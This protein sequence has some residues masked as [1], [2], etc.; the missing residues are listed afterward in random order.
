ME[1]HQRLRLSTTDGDD[2][3]KLK[4]TLSVLP[5]Y[6]RF[7]G[8]PSAVIQLYKVK[9]DFIYFPRFFDVEA[10]SNTGAYNTLEDNLSTG[11]LWPFDVHF[12]GELTPLQLRATNACY[13]Q[14]IKGKA[15][16]RVGENASPDADSAFR[17]AVDVN[18]DQRG[19]VKYVRH[20]GGGAIL[21]LHCG[22]GKTVCALQL[23]SRFRV[24]TLVIVHKTFLMDQWRKRISKFIPSA[25]VGT[26]QRDVV[27]VEGHDIVLAMLQSLAVKTYSLSVLSNF[28]LCVVDECHHISAP[29]FSNAMWNIPSRYVIGLSATPRRKDGLTCIMNW[30]LG[31]IAFI[32]AQAMDIPVSVLNLMIPSISTRGDVKVSNRY[33]TEIIT[34]L[35]ENEVRNHIIIDK[36]IECAYLERKILVLSDRRL[37]LET[38]CKLL[39]DASPEITAG[40]YVGGM[41]ERELETSVQC[42]VLFGTYSMSSEGLDIPLLDTLVLSTPR[43]DIVQSVGRIARKHDDKCEPLIID[44]I[45]RDEPGLRAGFRKRKVFYKHQGYSIASER[46]ECTGEYYFGDGGESQSSTNSFMDDDNEES[47]DEMIEVPR[48]SGRNEASRLSVIG[49][50]LQGKHWLNLQSHGYTSDDPSHVEVSNANSGNEAF[51]KYDRS[52]MYRSNEKTA[53]TESKSARNLGNVDV[54]YLSKPVGSNKGRG[55]IARKQGS[56]TI[57]IRTDDIANDAG[58]CRGDDDD[59]MVKS[60]R[61]RFEKID[62]EGKVVSTF[63]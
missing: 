23:M 45:D 52:G 33:Q 17:D 30:F 18:V 12:Q 29:V 27:D 22:A 13:V 20:T 60:K 53:N 41:K 26:I 4:D 1:G 5:F 56:D 49:R 9:N 37:H 36:V 14:M 38:L 62:E 44:V 28:G 43:T 59:C 11:V 58:D 15:G 3:K 63:F 31:P 57:C 51:E 7:S 48:T 24:K 2:L 16:I 40:Y 47:A 10:L 50:P 32:S 6:S 42:T 34:R 46:Y 25:S 19:S 54:L 61:G 21:S 39:R 8:Q 55:G 35:T